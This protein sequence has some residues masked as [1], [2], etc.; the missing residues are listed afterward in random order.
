[1][2]TQA[3]IYQARLR[4]KKALE[5]ALKD[6][7]TPHTVSG[8]RR[9]AWLRASIAKLEVQLRQEELVCID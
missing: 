8:Y 2:A 1:M 3:E 9:R 4:R 5:S 6:M 7:P